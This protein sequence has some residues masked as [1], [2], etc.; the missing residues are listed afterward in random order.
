V[1]F[2]T[3]CN[4]SLG[5][6][7]SWYF[8][9]LLRFLIRSINLICAKSC[10]ID[11]ALK[12]AGIKRSIE[13]IKDMF[14]GMKHFSEF[15]E[16]NPGLGAKVLSQRLKEM[17]KNGLI[18]KKVVS[19]T[20]LPIEYSLTE[21]GKA[22]NRVIYEMASFAMSACENEIPAPENVF[23][24]KE[25]IRQARASLKNVLEIVD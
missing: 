2:R 7:L 14:F 4:A 10:P 3:S 11:V 25:H 23:D 12:Y 22:L 5:T 24:S 16:A 17:E 21:K 6:G 20:P 15:L 13:L 1:H 19:V 18:V 8:L 9:A